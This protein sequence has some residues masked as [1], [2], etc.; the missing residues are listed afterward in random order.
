[1]ET[2]APSAESARRPIALTPDGARRA[3]LISELALYSLLLCF[4]PWRADPFLAGGLVGLY[5][6]RELDAQALKLYMV[7]LIAGALADLMYLLSHGVEPIGATVGLAQ[8]ALKPLAAYAAWHLLPE[9]PSSRPPPMAPD[10]LRDAVADAVRV[11]LEAADKRRAAAQP[12]Q[13]APSK[14]QA[15]PATA[16]SR[17]WEDEAHAV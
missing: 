2:D 10:A 17:S 15:K 8:L 6:A 14:P 11:A 3:G 7:L 4:L 13:P 12:A 16:R 9:L 5:A 1:M